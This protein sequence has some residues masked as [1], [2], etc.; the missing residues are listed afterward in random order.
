[1][2]TT[3]ETGPCQRPRLEFVHEKREQHTSQLS[4]PTHMVYVHNTFGMSRKE[5]AC[6]YTVLSKFI[7]A[8]DVTTNG[9]R[10]ARD[11]TI[12]SLRL[13]DSFLLRGG[14]AN[15][16]LQVTFKTGLVARRV[17]CNCIN[18][19]Y[20]SLSLLISR[21]FQRIMNAKQTEYELY[22]KTDVVYTKPLSQIEER[23]DAVNDNSSPS[24]E[25]HVHPH[26]EP[27]PSTK[28]TSQDFDKIRQKSWRATLDSFGPIVEDCQNIGLGLFRLT[29]FTELY[30]QAK[31]SLMLHNKFK[32]SKQ[33]PQLPA[34]HLG[35][36]PL[37]ES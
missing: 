35:D 25:T 30:Y 28:F 10:L 1:M 4:K 26:I 13:I 19:L 17:L 3:T 15:I 6:T 37:E 2:S 14:A 27:K 36:A 31:L 22:V 21:C 33:I 23:T 18:T 9:L 7:G 16:L 34:F 8:W 12:L 20:Q 5:I 24:Y 11:V 32:Q 29:P